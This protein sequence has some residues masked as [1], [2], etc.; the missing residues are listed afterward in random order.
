MD[1]C[2]SLDFHVLVCVRLCTCICTTVH[3]NLVDIHKE[4]YMYMDCK[5]SLIITCTCAY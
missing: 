1:I 2:V 3:C 4:H 5:C